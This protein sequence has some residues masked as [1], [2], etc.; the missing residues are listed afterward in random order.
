MRKSAFWFGVVFLAVVAF[1]VG[2]GQSRWKSDASSGDSLSAAR[3]ALQQTPVDAQLRALVAIFATAQPEDLDAIARAFEGTHVGAGPDAGAAELLGEIWGTLDPEGGLERISGWRPFRFR[4]LLPPLMSA[5]ARRDPEGARAAAASLESEEIRK[6]VESAIAL[7]RFEAA[8]DR[9]WAGYW[10]DWPF[11]EGVLSD[12]AGRI[13]LEDGLPA[14]FHRI[15]ALPAE[16]PDGLRARL[17]REAVFLGGRI[18]P[19]LTIPFVER[20]VDDS[21]EGLRNLL[22]PFVDAWARHDARSALDWLVARPPSGRRATAIR[23]AFQPWITAP[24]DRREAIEWLEARPDE[25]RAPV[26]DLLALAL[27]HVDPDRALA[28]AEAIPT[29][30]RANV[31]ERV[32]QMVSVRKQQAGV[33]PKEEGRAE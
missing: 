9:G 8:G 17:Y 33:R 1:T 2:Y 32:K 25:I 12:V 13:V 26:Q 10:R 16:A 30:N 22:A 14:L 6:Q 20:H 11:G 27:V 29:R 3:S 4:Q 19:A 5:W 15:E 31:V 24:D 7:A 21:I 28:V 23:I 18:D